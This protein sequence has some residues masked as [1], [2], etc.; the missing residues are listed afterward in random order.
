MTKLDFQ[1]F[2]IPEGICRSSYRTGDARE[3]VANMLY[4]NVN[5]IRAHALAMKIYRS[6]GPS[7]Y[8]DEEV[9]TL[10]EVANSYGT[11]A[12][13]DGLNEQIENQ[14]KTD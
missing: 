8:T 10:T 9:R 6:E 7:D 13:I 11:P 2:R 5:G 4:L 3:S 14:P 12:F 1:Q